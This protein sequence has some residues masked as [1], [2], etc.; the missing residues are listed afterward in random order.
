MEGQHGFIPPT[1]SKTED[2]QQSSF[3]QTGF[4]PVEPP[5]SSDFSQGGFQPVGND[6]PRDYQQT[7]FQPTNKSDSQ[8]FH[9]SGFQSTNMGFQPP[10]GQRK[11]TISAEK[12]SEIENAVKAAQGALDKVS[13]LVSDIVFTPQT[14]TG[15]D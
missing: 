6:G 15:F 2:S 13:K 8:G 9:Q 14:S 3:Q 5:L 11:T 7:G 10:S 4:K 1:E 12:L